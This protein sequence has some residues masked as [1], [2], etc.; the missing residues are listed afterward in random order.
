MEKVNLENFICKKQLD[1][2]NDIIKH[3]LDGG[4][5]KNVLESLKTKIKNMP[6][7]YDTW[8]LG[9]RARAILHYYNKNNHWYITEKDPGSKDDPVSGVQSQAYG[10]IVS[11][12]SF[13]WAWISIE[14]LIKDGIE[15]DLHFIPETISDIKQR[16]I[17]LRKKGA[18]NGKSY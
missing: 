17:A 11:E 15:L 10:F 7:V 9:D 5:F 8:V 14:R 3:S 12:N 1:L 16:T 4:H 2:I 6:E 18:C 13:D